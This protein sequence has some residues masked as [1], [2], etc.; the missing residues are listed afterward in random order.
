MSVP[1]KHHYVPQFLLLRFADA[2]GRL[3]V[4]RMT[5]QRAYKSN[6]RDI[7]HTNFGHTLYWPGVDPDHSFME[8][9]M[10]DIEGAAATVSESLRNSRTRNVTPE[11]RE[12]LGFL[13][14]LQWARSRFHLNNLV[15]SVMGT[16]SP[17][18][19]LA[20]SIGVRQVYRS[21]LAPWYARKDDNSH[22]KE[23]FCYI[24]DWLQHGPWSWRLYRPTVPKL[25]VSDNL[26]C[27]CGVADDATSQLPA[28]WTYHGVALGFGSCAR[29]TV[30]LA[31]DLGLVITRDSLSKPSPITAAAFN[32]ATVYNSREFVAHHPEGLPEVVLQSLRADMIT[33]RQILP[34]ILGA[35]RSES[36]RVADELQR[37]TSSLAVEDIF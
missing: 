4:H 36:E 31:P 21:V 27:M 18:D 17:S 20:K 19:E 3:S 1:R 14:A 26:V 28:P 10:S 11:N 33:Q 15:T 2:R 24:V 7:G 12:V 23:S 6:V 8:T 32:R 22:P 29:I 34:I 9:G 5:E 25:V 37:R 16:A 35:T 13:I 30:P